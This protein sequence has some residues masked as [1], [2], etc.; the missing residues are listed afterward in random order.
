MFINTYSSRSKKPSGLLFIFLPEMKLCGTINCS[1]AL[2]GRRHDRFEDAVSMGKEISPPNASQS[3]FKY[4]S[5]SLSLVEICF[6]AESIP[7]P[8][9]RFLQLIL[10]NID[11][12]G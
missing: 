2:V 10:P 5:I 9:D 8:I 4:K 7:L 12:L 3:L 6:N 1:E 11:F